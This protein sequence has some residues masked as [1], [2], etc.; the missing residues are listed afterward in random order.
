VACERGGLQA[1]GKI[2][3]EQGASCCA[4]TA[5]FASLKRQPPTCCQ[6]H[7]AAGSEWSDA[8]E[9][10]LYCH[11]LL[12]VHGSKYVLLLFFCEQRREGAVLAAIS[13]RYNGCSLAKWLI[14]EWDADE[15]RPDHGSVSLCM[16][17]HVR[18]TVT[19]SLVPL[20]R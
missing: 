18:L 11:P 7:A 14:D 19:P 20:A 2:R 17:L 13:S 5:T 1:T 4:V 16:R 3:A 15:V 6:W 9:S 8:L 10:L 12:A